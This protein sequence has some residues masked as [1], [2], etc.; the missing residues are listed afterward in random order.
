MA[1]VIVKYGFAPTFGLGTFLFDSLLLLFGDRGCLRFFLSIRPPLLS[2]FDAGLVA[3]AGG[4]KRATRRC[5]QGEQERPCDS[6][7]ANR[8]EGVFHTIQF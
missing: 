8:G 4:E 3:D 2:V 1:E 5:Y 6:L 7:S